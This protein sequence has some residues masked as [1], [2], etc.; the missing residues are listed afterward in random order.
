[1]PRQLDRAA[2]HTFLRALDGLADYTSAVCAQVDPEVFYP[3][4]GVSTADARWVCSG[5]P[6]RFTCLFE[7]I[8]NHE[9]FGVWGGL[10]E[11][12]RRVLV[13]R[14]VQGC[15]PPPMCEELAA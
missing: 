12:E 1:M 14:P 5:C 4:K 7:A 9:R 10:S 15:E 11:R 13:N 6:L 2:A 3:E 8:E